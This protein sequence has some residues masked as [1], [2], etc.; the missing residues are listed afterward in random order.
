MSRYTSGF[1][2]NSPYTLID[3]EATT[4]PINVTMKL[5]MGKP[6]IWPRIGEFAVVEFLWKSVALEANVEQLAAASRKNLTMVHAFSAPWRVEGS[7]RVLP[8]PPAFV[9]VKARRP[10]AEMTNEASLA[11]MRKPHF[12]LRFRST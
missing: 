1:H 8:I 7:L 11:W 2:T 9:K 3:E 4:I 6:M 5:E 10:A 12:G